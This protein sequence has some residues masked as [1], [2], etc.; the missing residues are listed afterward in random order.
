MSFFTIRMK[1]TEG[2]IV[3]QVGVKILLSN[4]EGQYLLLHRSEKKYPGIKDGWDIP[5]GRINPGSSLLENL[6]REVKEETELALEGAPKLVAA[7][8]ILRE[9]RHIVRLTYIGA[10][11]GELKLDTEEN[12]RFRW[13]T[14]DEFKKVP[15]LDSYLKEVLDK[16][17]F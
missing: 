10:S 8:D 1:S 6:K 14:L 12:D 17:L 3:L 4:E 11:S 16:G 13:C 9:G 2:G 5:G 15:D 7:Q